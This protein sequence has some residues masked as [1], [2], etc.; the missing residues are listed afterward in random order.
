MINMMDTLN[1]DNVQCFFVPVYMDAET[2]KI[3]YKLT[4]RRF[5]FEQKLPYKSCAYD[6]S[7][8]FIIFDYE[9]NNF[10]L[11]SPWAYV[12]E[13]GVCTYYAP[14]EA[15]ADTYPIVLV[16]NKY[17][18]PLNIKRNSDF[19]LLRNDF[20]KLNLELNKIN[21]K[22]RNKLEELHAQFQCKWYNLK[23]LTQVNSNIVGVL[24]SIYAI[25]QKFQIKEMFQR[26]CSKHNL[27][28]Q[29]EILEYCQWADLHGID[30]TMGELEEALL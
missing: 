16:V 20:I 24:I 29:K 30:I 13:N 25:N 19:R 15:L 5:D 28:R 18:V 27:D 8:T 3:K 1:G 10:E 26:Y 23:Q 17:G 4:K 6:Y 12:I 21:P 7:D 14:V 2:L 9:S 22:D 11:N